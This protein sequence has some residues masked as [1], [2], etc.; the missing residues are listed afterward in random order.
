MLRKPPSFIYLNRITEGKLPEKVELEFTDRYQ[1]LGIPYP[2]PKTQC[3][4]HCEGTGF[5][6]IKKDEDFNKYD[7]RFQ[8][9]WEENEA[10]EPSEDGW[11]FI[12]CPDCEGT[13]LDPKS[14]Y[15]IITGEDQKECPEEDNEFVVN[16]K[17]EPVHGRQVTKV[18][19]V[20]AVGVG[21]DKIPGAE[22][23]DDDE[24]EPEVSTEEVMDTVS[25]VLQ[26]VH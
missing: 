10:T 1:A 19:D 11:H 16:L 22:I 4:G 7:P 20:K 21:I 26:K 12:V 18:R 13:G 23:W 8:K 9:R 17:Q 6:P 14:Q 15:G 2:D 5:V 25:N 3:K 24:E